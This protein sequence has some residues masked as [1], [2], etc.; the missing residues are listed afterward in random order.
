MRPPLPLCDV[1]ERIKDKHKG[2]VELIGH[3]VN[4]TTKTEF[5][6]KEYGSFIA[7]PSNVMRG[8]RHR[9]F[10]YRNR[11]WKL[12]DV[13]KRIYAIHGAKVVIDEK[14][15]VNMS[16][17]ARFEDVDYGEWWT[18]P[19]NVFLLGTRHPKRAI[20]ESHVSITV[21]LDEFKKRLFDSRGSTITVVDSSFECTGK[22]ALFIDEQYGEF[23]AMPHNILKGSDHPVLARLKMLR[24]S[25]LTTII[26]HWKTNE[27]L[28]CTGSYEVAFVNWCNK[29]QI[30]FCWQIPHK[31]P[32][33]KTFYVDAYI[34]S[35]KFA[36]TWIE[37]KGTWCRDSGMVSKKKWEWFHEK[38]SNSLLWM[39][40]DLQNLNIIS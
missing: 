11:S 34:K 6:D 19:G 36:N 22:S 13:K 21:S 38:F 29:N 27:E 30:D 3:Y 1:I 16:T 10:R 2:K 18:L 24:N 17:K 28:M 40:K 4:A 15:F 9:N 5:L 32:D 35:G 20:K 8:T 23:R 25:K 39:K 12:D 37:I 7:T 26:K 33:N 31:M 14:T